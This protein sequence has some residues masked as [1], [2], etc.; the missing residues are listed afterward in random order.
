MRLANK[1]VDAFLPCTRR[2]RQWSDKL[3]FVQ[4]PLIPGYVFVKLAL[5]SR[6]RLRT[7]ET[8]GVIRS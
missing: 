1:G 6:L 2:K 8:A 3:E 7:V 5:T 4:T